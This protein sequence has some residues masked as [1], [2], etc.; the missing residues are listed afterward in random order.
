MPSGPLG[1]RRPGSLPRATAGPAGSRPGAGARRARRRPGRC[2]RSTRPEPSSVSGRWRPAGGGGPCAARAGPCGGERRSSRRAGWPWPPAERRRC[3][4]HACSRRGSGP[5]PSAPSRP[6]RGPRRDAGRAAPAGPAGR[7]GRAGPVPSEAA[8]ASWWTDRRP[9]APAACPVAWESRSP[10]GR[11]F[12]RPARIRPSP[13]GPARPGTPVRE[14]VW[15]AWRVTGSAGANGPPGVRPSE[16]AGRQALSANSSR[17]NVTIIPLTGAPGSTAR[18]RRFTSVPVTVGR[19]KSA[20]TILGVALAGA[21]AIREA[22]TTPASTG[23]HVKLCESGIRPLE[24]H[25][26]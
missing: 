18:I 21:A 26:D 13:R 10:A 1:A 12:R 25:P 4:A 16:P 20:A 2:G 9:A 11:R 24:G 7:A 23:W 22:S 17:P 19:S 8:R 6:P 15:G 3:C 14:N 5:R